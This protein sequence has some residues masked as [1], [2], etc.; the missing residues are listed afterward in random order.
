[1]IWLVPT[2]KNSPV[3]I[4]FIYI[5][6]TT[7]KTTMTMITIKATTTARAVAEMGMRLEFLHFQRLH[8]HNTLFSSP[9]RPKKPSKIDMYGY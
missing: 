2:T 4:L 7:T 9:S 3:N 6:S 1:M 8:V 5:K